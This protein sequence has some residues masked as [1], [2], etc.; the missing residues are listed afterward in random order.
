MLFELCAW[1]LIKNLNSEKYKDTLDNKLWQIVTKQFGREPFIFQDDNIPCHWS[2][3]VEE[4]K[5]QN[6][7]S[8]L[9]WRAQSP[10]IIPKENIG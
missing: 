3:I 9:S 5:R 2:R 7:F 1:L 8:Q 6:T 4:W 10:D